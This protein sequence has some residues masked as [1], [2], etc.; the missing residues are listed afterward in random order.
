MTT[1]TLPQLPRLFRLPIALAPTFVKIAVIER[2]LNTLF[3]EALKN[4]ELE[5]LRDRYMAIRVSDA[6]VDFSIGLHHDA[7]AADRPTSVPDV[8]IEGPA[9]AFL[10]LGTRKEDADTLFF[11]RQLKTHGDTELGLLIK[12]FLDSLEPEALPYH[13][14]TDAVLSNALTVAN[15]L[16]QLREAFRWNLTRFGF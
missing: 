15:N 16:A 1:A 3:A 13:Q 8:T 2:V 7:I 14:L 9:Y 5:F 10:L 12:N 11:R 6:G 4:G